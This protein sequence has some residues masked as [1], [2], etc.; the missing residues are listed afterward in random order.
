MVNKYPKDWTIQDKNRY[1]KYGVSPDDFRKLDKGFCPLCLRNWS[2]RVR[3]CIDHDHSTQFVR[4]I[5]CT[6]CNRYVL[7]RLSSPDLVQRIFD[8][9]SNQPKKIKVPPKKKKKKKRKIK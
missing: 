4:G 3:P 6:Y 2:D 7:G 9:L 8:Y 1:R 5:L